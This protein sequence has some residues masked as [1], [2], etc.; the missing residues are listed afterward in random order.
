MNAGIPEELLSAYLDGQLGPVELQRVEAALAES[1]T[2]QN[3][4]KSLATTRNAVHSLPAAT[5]GRDL[6]ADIFAEITRRSATTTVAPEVAV[7][8]RPTPAGRV[9]DRHRRNPNRSWRWIG[10]GAAAA[11]LVAGL[12]AV[13]AWL[14]D[15]GDIPH[16]DVA[17][18]DLNN[19]VPVTV[20]PTTVEEK[21]DANPPEAAVPQPEVHAPN[22]TELM[23][24]GDNRVKSEI[25]TAP[26]TL[27]D[28][29]PPGMRIKITSNPATEVPS[30]DKMETK[31]MGTGAIA[32]AT[33]N[34]TEK[35]DAAFDRYVKPT[36]FAAEDRR[37][38]LSLLA[39]EKTD[40]AKEVSDIEMLAG[41]RKLPKILTSTDEDLVELISKLDLDDNNQID[42]RELASCLA[43]ARF[44]ETETG[45]Q[46]ARLFFRIDDNH[47]GVWTNEEVTKNVRLAGGLD[48]EFTRKIRLWDQNHDGVVNFVEAE[49][50]ASALQREFQLIEGK[51]YDSQILA[52]AQRLFASLDRSGDGSLSGRELTRALDTPEIAAAAAGRKTL[53]LHELY[54]HLETIALGL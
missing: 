7:E 28:R 3:Q 15:N 16:N 12:L 34:L 37:Q 10:V 24:T 20:S 9:T 23:G 22:F 35:A 2:L 36:D 45:R 52:Q 13:P 26:A 30:P 14:G 50:G 29:K 53:S 19:D 6:T 27:P 46:V 11:A 43:D 44:R 39:T 41:L 25:P 5:V 21:P 18:V 54:L 33:P 40:T 49:F 48:Q 8:L 17:N 1:P 4:L 51:L 32:R 31:P 47:D 42:D 38:L